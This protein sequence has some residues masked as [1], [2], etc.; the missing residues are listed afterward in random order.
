MSQ[1]NSFIITKS[2]GLKIPKE[3]P[4]FLVGD[5][6]YLPIPIP[7]GYEFNDFINSVKSNK[8]FDIA[9]YY[10]GNFHFIELIRKLNISSFVAYHSSEFGMMTLNYYNFTVVNDAVIEKSIWSTE[11]GIITPENYSEVE[12]NYDNNNSEILLNIKIDG[13][14]I[15][16]LKYFEIA[17]SLYKKWGNSLNF[18]EIE[19]FNSRKNEENRKERLE[20]ENQETR[21]FE[22]SSDDIPS[23][24]FW[25]EIKR[26]LKL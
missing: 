14:F 3:I 25:G 7:T 22:D 1:D 24:S 19:K 23:N 21:N 12:E 6:I 15:E 11:E 9:D 4:H 18:S 2:K 10:S 17:E 8:K 13:H 16:Q 20:S 26:V 5:D